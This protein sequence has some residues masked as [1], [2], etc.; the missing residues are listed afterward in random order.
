MNSKQLGEMF[1]GDSAD[2]RAEK[3]PLLSMGAEWR[4]SRAQTQERGPSLAIV[5]ISRVFLLENSLSYLSSEELCHYQIK[6]KVNVK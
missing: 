5:E 6:M 3:F 1:E 2:M 4:V